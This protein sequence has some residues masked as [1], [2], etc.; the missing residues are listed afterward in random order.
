MSNEGSEPVVANRSSDRLTKNSFVFHFCI[1]LSDLKFLHING[2]SSVQLCKNGLSGNEHNLNN[3][4]HTNLLRSGNLYLFGRKTNRAKVLTEDGDDSTDATNEDDNSV[5]DGEEG[6]D[7]N[8][9]TK[10]QCDRFFVRYAIA[11]GTCR[12]KNAKIAA[13]TIFDVISHNRTN[14]ELLANVNIRH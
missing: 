10:I 7:E 6:G 11:M 5:D 13:A 12:P 14:N 4:S 8:V 3:E 2:Q 1:F 9:E